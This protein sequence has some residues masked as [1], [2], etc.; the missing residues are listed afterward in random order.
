M[1]LIIIEQV[2]QAFVEKTQLKLLIIIKAKCPKNRK[3]CIMFIVY[4]NVCCIR[5]MLYMYLIQYYLKT[6]SYCLYRSKDM[7]LSAKHI[8]L[9]KRNTT[10]LHVHEFKLNK[11]IYVITKTGNLKMR[12]RS[13]ISPRKQRGY[14]IIQN[15]KHV[16]SKKKSNSNN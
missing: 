14:L 8:I 3:I 16:K 15:F 12:K 9:N 6:A 2:L 10:F 5:I 7:F 4:Q 13:F 11:T 1:L